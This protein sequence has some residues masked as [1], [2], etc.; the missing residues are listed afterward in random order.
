MEKNDKEFKFSEVENNNDIDNKSLIIGRNGSGKSSLLEAMDFTKPIK[1]YHRDVIVF[2]KYKNEIYSV[3]SSSELEKKDK[4]ANKIFGE[5]NGKSPIYN[6]DARILIKNSFK[7]FNLHFNKYITNFSKEDNEVKREISRIVTL[8]GDIKSLDSKSE[9][10]MIEKTYNNK[11]QYQQMM[12]LP[13]DL[14]IV[15]GVFENMFGRYRN[16]MDEDI[17]N[18]LFKNF[19]PPFLSKEKNN[20]AF[21]TL[22][23][24]QKLIILWDFQIIYNLLLEIK[25]RNPKILDDFRVSTE[26][27]YAEVLKNNFKIYNR[28]FNELLEFIT[29]IFTEEIEKEIRLIK[30]T[31][32]EDILLEGGQHKDKDKYNYDVVLKKYQKIRRNLGSRKK[33]Y[34]NERS[35]IFQIPFTEALSF[36]LK[37]LLKEERAFY[38]PKMFSDTIKISNNIQSTGMRKVIQLLLSIE[39]D[40]EN[41]DVILIDEIDAFLYP[42]LSRRFINFI[43]KHFEKYNITDKQLIFTSHSPFILSDFFEKQVINLEKSKDASKYFASN[44]NK[45]LSNDFVLKGLIGEYATE[46]IESMEA[47]DVKKKMFIINNISDPIIKGMLKAKY[48]ISL[49][50]PEIDNMDIEELE[51]LQIWLNQ[52]MKDE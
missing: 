50:K 45:I 12:P 30:T 37:D 13:K 24:N 51:E 19:F 1:R 20:L 40:I 9:I 36:A 49:E 44:F 33:V 11:K 46:L 18:D 25:K 7:G 47:F 42:E 34:F 16:K 27:L 23:N 14:E 43:Y 4:I 22:P 32:M 2:V 6:Y 3:Y 10:E 31:N 38:I 8:S 28:K 52:R 5:M 21:T 35:Y 39:K 41:H 15:I 29:K 26:T 48:L 17:M